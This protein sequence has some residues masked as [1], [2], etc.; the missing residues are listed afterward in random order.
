MP[1]EKLII[2]PKSKAE[3]GGYRTFSIRVKASTADGVQQLARLTGRSRNDIVQTMLEYALSR[4][5]IKKPES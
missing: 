1:G 3:R 2:V 4:Y 5:E